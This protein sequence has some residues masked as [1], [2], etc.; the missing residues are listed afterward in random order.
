MPGNLEDPKH[1]AFAR[2]VSQGKSKREAAIL[3]GFSGK[4]ASAAGSKLAKNSKVKQ[5]IAELQAQ[6]AE[7][8]VELATKSIA[9]DIASKEARVRL[10]DDLRRRLMLI[11]EERG[12]DPNLAKA[13]G[14]KS[15]LVCLRVKT[16]GTGLKQRLVPEYYTDTDLV[17]EVRAIAQQAAEELGQWKTADQ[18][19][20]DSMLKELSEALKNSPTTAVV[21]ND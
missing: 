21:V 4:Y 9:L 5:R 6:V 14:G 19:A 20:D 11:V 3:A 7:K 10:Y 12:Q 15:G 2:F 17:R 1:E 18:D 8:T 16:V 13:P